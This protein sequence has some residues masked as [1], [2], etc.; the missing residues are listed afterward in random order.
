MSQSRIVSVVKS[1][2]NFVNVF[3]SQRLPRRRTTIGPI[4]LLP[5]F[6]WWTQP[7]VTRLVVMCHGF[8]DLLGVW[9]H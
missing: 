9:H 4:P 7:T 5:K 1:S 2:A 8:E 3:S 6:S